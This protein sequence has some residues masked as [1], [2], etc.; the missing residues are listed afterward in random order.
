MSMLLSDLRTTFGYLVQAG[1][2]R[3]V[4]PL[5]PKAPPRPDYSAVYT[6]PDFTV[7]RFGKCQAGSYIEVYRP[8]TPWLGQNGRPKAVIFLHGFVL[9]AAQIYRAHL[10]H[11]V[12]QGYTVFFPNFQTG[13]C[14]FPP[15]GLMTVAELLD[16]VF[17]DGLR[18]SQE[19][20]MKNALASVSDAYARVG[21]GPDVAVDTYV[22]GHSLGG[23]F[24]L[25]WPWYVTEDGLPANLMPL[26]VVTA[27]P[28]PSSSAASAPGQIGQALDSLQDDVNLAVTGKA[29]TMPVAILH[30]D[31]DWIVPKSEWDTPFGAIATDRKRMYLSQTDTHGCPGHFAN[32]EQATDDTSFFRPLLSLLLLDGV[33]AEDTLDWRYLWSA[34]DRVIRE[35]ARADQLDFDMGQWS[36]GRPVRPVEVYL[37]GG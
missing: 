8:E 4:G 31:A 21:F 23:L 30:G 27:D 37:S 2:C 6:S 15:R 14:S 29:L 16:E 18:P 36:D 26:Q 10:E 19:T 35:G 24:A 28:V 20:W 34:L 5:R 17:G 25:S 13:F 12:R 1:L 32:H 33:G 3:L 11:L 7:E 9:G 22:Y